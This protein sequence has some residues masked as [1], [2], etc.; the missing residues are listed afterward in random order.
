MLCRYCSL[1]HYHYLLRHI[2]RLMPYY[3][4]LLPYVSQAGWCEAMHVWGSRASFGLR[5]HCLSFIFVFSRCL[6]RH[7]LPLWCPLFY[8]TTSLYA[9]RYAF[10]MIRLF[11]HMPFAY[12]FRVI[13]YLSPVFIICFSLITPTPLARCEKIW[14]A[15]LILERKTWEVGAE[16]HHTVYLRRFFTTF[17]R[18]TATVE[19]LCLHF[20]NTSLRHSSISPPGNVIIFHCFITRIS[21]YCF[22]FLHVASSSF[23]HCSS[24]SFA[25]FLFVISQHNHGTLHIASPLVYAFFTW[26]YCEVGVTGDMSRFWERRYVMALVTPSYYHSH[27]LAVCIKQ[28][29][30]ALR[31]CKLLFA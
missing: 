18:H 3:I 13:T 20:F 6:C 29:F 24:F 11:T 4:L 1:F 14:H 17:Y 26:F 27:W 19:G 23:R 10:T 2:F 8:D 15:T 28:V 5:K 21:R 25:T 16:N 9:R 12:C 31:A 30:T 22:I 7:I